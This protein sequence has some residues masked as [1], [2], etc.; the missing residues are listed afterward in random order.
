MK[1]DSIIT[2]TLVLIA[3]CGIILLN[4]NDRQAIAQP[5]PASIGNVQREFR[6]TQSTTAAVYPATGALS[7]KGYSICVWN[8]D[9]AAD[10][11]YLRLDGTAASAAEANCDTVGCKTIQVLPGP[12][13]KVC[14]DQVFDTVNLDASADTPFRMTI[15]QRGGQN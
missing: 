13:Q 2:L 12:T 8:D 5:V 6:G 7:P 10:I 4:W 1:R 3:I 11:L 9:G 14:I 15:L